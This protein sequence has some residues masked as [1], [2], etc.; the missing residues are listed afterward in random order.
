VPLNI[1]RSKIAAAV[2][3]CAAIAGP[4][5]SAQAS[6]ETVAK[7]LRG[8]NAR[9]IRDELRVANGLLSYKSHHRAG[10]AVAALRAEVADLNAL[11]AKVKPESASTSRGATGKAEI[12][13]GLELISSSYSALA[14]DLRNAH[15]KTVAVKKLKAAV[16][17]DNA[18][19]KDLVAGGKLL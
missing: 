14:I 18:G 2:A 17:I 15:G 8:D 10:P 4:V 1:R 7:T 16:A 9:L 11:V 13:K 19:R 12:L 5:A 3:A 6:N